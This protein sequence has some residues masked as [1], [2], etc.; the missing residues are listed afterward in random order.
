MHCLG[1]VIDKMSVTPTFTLNGFGT[2]RFAVYS[3]LCFV[4]SHLKHSAEHC[5][6]APLHQGS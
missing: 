3:Q 1:A 4:L 2:A 6:N 5:P